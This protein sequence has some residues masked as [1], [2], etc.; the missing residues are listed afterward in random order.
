[1]NP[2][3]EDAC[4]DCRIRYLIRREVV[5]VETERLYIEDGSPRRELA[6]DL[7]PE[8]GRLVH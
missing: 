3:F 7:K 4:L 2:K 5:L 1:M 8:R 6:D